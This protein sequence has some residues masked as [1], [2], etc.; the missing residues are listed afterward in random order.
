[1]EME[2]D[3]DELDRVLIGLKLKCM[4]VYAGMSSKELSEKAC[5]NHAVLRSI[6]IGRRPILPIQVGAIAAVLGADARSI[7]DGDIALAWDGVSPFTPHTYKQ[8]LARGQRYDPE[9]FT[10]VLG[11]WCREFE[12]KLAKLSTAPVIQAWYFNWLRASSVMVES[13]FDRGVE[14][15]GTSDTPL[16]QTGKGITPAGL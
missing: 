16:P 10:K 9:Q 8:W 6:E 1:M 15:G 14:A 5:I 3:C 2:E 11:D 4:R 13:A 12:A 7:I